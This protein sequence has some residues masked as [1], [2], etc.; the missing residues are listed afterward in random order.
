[1][2]N[3]IDSFAAALQVADIDNYIFTDQD[4]NSS[5]LRTNR[6]P[7]DYTLEKEKFS[8]ISEEL[9]LVLELL[10][11]SPAEFKACLLK[12]EFAEGGVM[13]KVNAILRKWGWKWDTIRST[14]QELRNF[15]TL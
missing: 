6:T 13:K 15:L 11:D 1:M 4:P 12:P 2:A 10:F 8:S 5:I 14:K 3:K 9:R 7:E